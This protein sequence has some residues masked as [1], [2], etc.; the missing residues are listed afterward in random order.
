VVL[1]ILGRWLSAHAERK[2]GDNLCS[3][4]NGKGTVENCS[5]SFGP[6]N[7]DGSQ[8]TTPN[9]N[10]SLDILETYKQVLGGCNPQNDALAPIYNAARGLAVNYIPTEVD[11]EVNNFNG[12]NSTGGVYI[13]PPLINVVHLLGVDVANSTSQFITGFQGAVGCDTLHDVYAAAKNSFCCDV[14]TSFYWMIASWYLIAWSMLLC[15]CG[16][17]LL[18]RKRFPYSL[19]GRH[20]EEDLARLNQENSEVED[21]VPNNNGGADVHNPELLDDSRPGA[22]SRGISMA[23]PTPGVGLGMG[24]SHSDNMGDAASGPEPV[25][26]DDLKTGSNL[27]HLEQHP[28]EEEQHE[29]VIEPT[30]DGEPPHDQQH[31]E[32]NEG[33]DNKESSQERPQLSSKEEGQETWAVQ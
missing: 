24:L 9:F 6:N 31:S 25:Q 2:M 3:D 10:F 1:C 13:E 29:Y 11:R 14:L 4:A 28:E 17:S 16:A 27:P 7:T 18:G 23:S 19:W 20:I 21:L 33:E 30:V 8:S 32:V 22:P 12:D 26:L 5:F 15:G